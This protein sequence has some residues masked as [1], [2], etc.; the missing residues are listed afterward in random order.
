[1]QVAVENTGS[2]E[3]RMKVEVPEDRIAQEVDSRLRNMMTS[4]RIPGFRPGKVPMKV[5]TKRFGRQVRDE[6]VSE[7]MRSSFM[8]A[9]T[10]QNLRP[11]GGPTI[12]P[13]EAEPGQG[14]SYTAVFEVYPEITLT[15]VEDLEVVRPEAQV[16]DADIERMIGVLQDQRKVFNE[17]ERAAAN[18]DKVACDFVGRIDGEEFE[19]GKADGFEIELGRGGFIEGFEDGL[20]GA[21]PGS[22]RML[23]LSFPEDYGQETLAGKAVQFEVKIHKV[24]E[25][26][27][28][29]LNED[30]V[31]QFGVEDGTEASFRVEI[32][33][34][35]ERELENGIKAMTK[36]RVLSALI[37]KNPVEMPQ[38]LITEECQR[39]VERRQN[40]LR[41]SGIDPQM[42]PVE[43]ES[44]AEEATRRVQLGLLL[45]EI[46]KSS[47]LS[48]DP[49]KVRA[50]VERIAT[51][52]EDPN[53][54]INYFYGEPGRLA[55]IESQVL[56]EAAIES[57]LS[58]A[59]VTV[60][61]SSFDALMNPGQTTP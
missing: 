27:R 32:R 51:S 56:E 47:E 58:R 12:D 40:E 35:M 23:D 61:Q 55:E 19:G 24:L 33:G 39:M 48:A 38:A 49:G 26:S 59:K 34:N 29:E 6:V 50:E 44:F 53:Q 30:F 20:V 1:M 7:V 42:M 3:R 54:V 31:K 36:D 17:V 13:V 21:T 10:E 60:E 43:P 14:L 52:Y 16:E 18:G 46:I 28:P 8:D 15:S 11:A 2:L 57:I 4:A 41:Q 22:E 9:L 5:I 25:G 45:A 37:E